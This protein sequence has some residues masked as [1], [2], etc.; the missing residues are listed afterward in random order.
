MFLHDQ[1]HLPPIETGCIRRSLA[2]SISSAT[3]K[4]VGHSSNRL[5]PTNSLHALEYTFWHDILS[6]PACS[7]SSHEAPRPAELLWICM[8]KQDRSVHRCLP[9]SEHATL[10]II[11]RAF[12]MSL[13]PKPTPPSLI[14]TI[15][16]CPAWRAETFQ[17][18]FIMHV[19]SSPSQS[20]SPTTLPEARSICGLCITRVDGGMTTAENIVCLS[21][22]RMGC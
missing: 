20:R 17:G 1:I 21:E 22:Y 19:V 9:I 6:L 4:G 18:L 15:T 3:D 11:Q 7:P 13:P 10:S 5:C 2:S 16:P 12:S 14:R 8:L